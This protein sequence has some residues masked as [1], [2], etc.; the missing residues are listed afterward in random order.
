MITDSQTN[1]FLALTYTNPTVVRRY[2]KRAGVSPTRAAL[3]WRELMKFLV[4]CALSKEVLAPSRKLDEIWHE[5]LLHTRDYQDFCQTVLGVFVHH[6]PTDTVNPGA[7]NST[8]STLSQRF[9]RPNPEVWPSN[10]AGTCDAN[11][12]ADCR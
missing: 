7:Y 12:C 2:A 6:Q 9:G 8:L 10:L 11:N 1:P 4:A 5:F 3:H